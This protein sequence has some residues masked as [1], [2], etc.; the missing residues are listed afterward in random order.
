VLEE[1]DRLVAAMRD[2]VVNRVSGAS[3]S[4]HMVPGSALPETQ[5]AHL[6][7]AINE[8]DDAIAAIR[9]AVFPRSPVEGP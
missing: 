8:L 3:L 1:Q 9:S 5:Q 6:W 4:L 2:T 7:Q